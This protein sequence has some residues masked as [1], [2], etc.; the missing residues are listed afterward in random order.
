MRNQRDDSGRN[1]YTV[2]NIAVDRALDCN[3]VQVS[4]AVVACADVLGNLIRDLIE[5]GI[6]SGTVS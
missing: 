4:G 5:A 1:Q 6:I 3:E 2:T